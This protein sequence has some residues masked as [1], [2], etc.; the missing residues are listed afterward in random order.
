[1]KFEICWGLELEINDKENRKQY[2]KPR[3]QIFNTILI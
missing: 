3:S 1:M 2:W